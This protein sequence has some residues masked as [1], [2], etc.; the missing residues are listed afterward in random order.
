MEFQML[1]P[2]EARVDGRRLDL[3]AAK[4]RSLL[5]IL[6][7]HANEPV[8]SDRLIDDLWAGRP[9]ATATKTLQTYVSQLRKAFSESTIVT[10]PSGY[11]FNVGR[12]SLDAHRFER[13]LGEARGADPA[14]AEDT[15]RRALALWRGPALVDFAFEPWAHAEIARLAE[16]RLDGLQDRIDADLALGGAAELVAELES[17]VDQHPLRERLRGQLMLA[18]Y[19]SGRQADAL[20]AYRAARATLVEKL[21]IEP[22]PALRRLERSILDQDPELDARTTGTSAGATVRAAPSLGRSTS[23]VGREKELR[24]IRELLDRADVRLLTLIGPAG[25]GKTR[26]AVEATLGDGGSRETVFVELAPVFDPGLVA[27]TIATTLGLSETS[28]AR[29]IEALVLRLGSQRTLLVL[30]NLEQVLDAAPVL[31]ELLTSA[32]G[33]QLLATSRAP[34]DR[35]EEH[36][37]TVPPLEEADAIRLFDDRARAARGD[38]ALSDENAEAVAELCVR[39]DGLPLAVELAAA[40]IKLLSPRAILERLG[41]RLELLKAVPG[42]GLPE[43][44]RTLRTA[45]DWSYDLLT[46]DEQ[47]LFTSLGVF[48]GGFSLDGAI[49]IAGDLDLDVVD[50]IESLL[51]NSLLRTERMSEGEPRFGMLE[52]M[53]EYAL[54]RL[55]TR[56]DGEAMRR[57]HADFYLRLAEDAE[58]AL[59]GPDQLRR[60]RKLDSERDNLRAAL[61]WAAESGE[62]EVG[63]RTASALWRFWQMRA[64]DVEGRG[65]LDRLLASGT[66]SPSA[67]AVAQS[68]AASLAYYQGDFSAVHRYHEASLP[69]FRELGD[70]YNLWCGLD[71][72]TMTLLAEGDADAARSVADDVLEMA[73]QTHNRFRQANSLSHLGIV[74]AAQGELA[75]GQGAIEDAVRQAQELGN[76][77]SIAHWTKA[78]G[79]I[80]VLQ[81]EHPRA[82]DLLEQSLSLYRSLDDAWGILGSIS[83]L[84]LVA[85]DEHDNGRA[86]RL[87]RESIEL[88]RKNGHHYRAAKLLDL[89]ARL[90]ADEGRNR[91]AAGLFASANACR[92]S[93]GAELFEGEVRP[94]PAPYIG[95]LRSALGEAAFCEAWTQGQAMTLDQ[96]LDYAL[97]ECADHARERAATRYKDRAL[98][99]KAAEYETEGV[100]PPSS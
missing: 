54:E 96:A 84:A 28:R 17:L 74:L 2:F 27:T 73:R 1:G 56:G 19:R 55:A 52:T 12:D 95:Q 76:V 34:L 99:A 41:G 40:R 30:D 72:L 61:S 6:L 44:H 32:P 37:Y 70:E 16:L 5:A 65:H 14:V 57:R 86:R 81:Q 83:S 80:A 21:G 53:R 85:L 78:L 68:R 87:L 48:V 64:A 62:T 38:F 91:R 71:Q 98:A 45:V 7:L 93:G 63:L 46:T 49:A 9:P 66:G 92:E 94:D 22:G 20:A 77:R 88:L 29:A 42:A 4:P 13:L 89:S 36:I 51:N 10:G 79:A 90:A 60:A 47:M 82:R 67:R 100:S 35:P 39:L 75:A 50:G 26:L 97:D 11:R 58:P 31:A 18:L 24:E 25:T 59:L 69:I 23:F 33:V 8:S 43:R 15:L 3:R